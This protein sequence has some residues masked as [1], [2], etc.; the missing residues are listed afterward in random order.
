MIRPRISLLL[1]A[2]VAALSARADLRLQQKAVIGF[3]VGDIAKIAQIDRGSAGPHRLAVLSGDYLLALQWSPV[4]N[5]YDQTFFVPLSFPEPYNDFKVGGA[6]MTFADVDGDG[7][8]DIVVFAA[9]PSSVVAAYDSATGAL[10]RTFDLGASTD[11]SADAVVAQDIDGQ[12]GDE[13]IVRSVY[14]DVSA[15]KGD[16]R[17]WQKT[18]AGFPVRPSRLSSE[19]GEVF[20]TT[21]KDIVVLDARTGQERRRLPV[22]CA[23]A[24]LGQSLGKATIACSSGFD[25]QV[26]DAADGAVLWKHALNPGYGLHGTEMFDVDGDGVDDA[27]VRTEP[28]AYKELLTVFNGRTGAVIATSKP[29][30]DGGPVAGIT[31]DCERPMLAIGTGGGSSVADTLTLLDAATLDTKFVAPFDEYGISGFAVAD[32]GGHG[33]AET[34]VEHDGKV[35]TMSV[36]PRSTEDSMA[37]GD[38]PWAG[39]R[40]MAAAQ[41]DGDAAAEV[42][43]AG[44]CGGYVGCVTAWDRPTPAKLWS[45]KMDDGEIPRCVVIADVDGDGADDVLS[46]SVAVHSGAKGEFAYAF[47]GRD[48]KQLWRSNNIPASTGRVRF[49]DVDGNGTPQVLI[50]SNTIGIVRLNRSN[51]QVAGFYEFSDGTAFGTYTLRG[52]ARAKVVAAAGTRLFI[53]DGG[54]VAKEVRDPDGAGTTEIEVA[55]VDGDGV[56]EI[57]LAQRVG[58]SGVRLQIRSLDTLAPLWTSEVFPLLLNFSQIE[59]IAVTD[60]DN[61]GIAEVAL[62]SSLTLRV[63]KAEA[64]PA[65]AIPPRFDSSAVLHANPRIHSCCTSV[66]L[67]WSAARPGSSPPLQYRVYRGGPAGSE[68]LLATTSRNELV[69]ANPGAPGIYR[70]SVAVIDA[71]GN[72]SA[73]RLNA[74]AEVRSC[75]RPPGKR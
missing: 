8:N 12:P 32:F 3:P 17:L 13:M 36:E 71:A 22:P 47:R 56:P 64:P 26:L 73:E 68:V 58:F 74:T 15:Y 48:G 55:D 65:G 49:A 63:F 44:V 69:D 28:A 52:D 59:Q 45:A 29:I 2:F 43:T 30:D 1:L 50:L 37:I 27:I 34:A 51:G 72:E 5:A 31:E 4:R 67:D 66:V 60:V 62:L 18:Q 41:L 10:L 20:L 33:L 11:F 19:R 23:R 75:F 38:G 54:Q 9:Y 57:L 61:D 16:R 21:E 24:A 39:Y 14:G 70:Y 25:L 42:V 35:L 7:R 46:A 53:L 40:G 6:T